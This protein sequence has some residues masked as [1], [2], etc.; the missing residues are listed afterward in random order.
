MSLWLWFS[1][2]WLEMFARLSAQRR[3][4]QLKQKHIKKKKKR[5]CGVSFLAP[6]LLLLLHIRTARA[7]RS[8]V[9]FKK[10]TV[11]ASK[12]SNPHLY[13]KFGIAFKFDSIQ[14]YAGCTVGHYGRFK[15]NYFSVLSVD[16]LM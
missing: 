16:V 8:D 1:L 12:L 13:L 3:K 5:Q 7:Q 14:S 4:W 2:V 9:L 10:L 6:K 15:C 11:A